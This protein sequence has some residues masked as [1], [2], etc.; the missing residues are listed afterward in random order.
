MTIHLPW[1]L[2]AT[3]DFACPFLLL[4]KHYLALR[5]TNRALSYFER[6]YR[7]DTLFLS[8]YREASQVFYQ[9]SQ[10]EQMIKV[11][12]RALNHGNRYW[13]IYYNLGIAFMIGNDIHH[14]I[15]N[16]NRALEIHPNNYDTNLQLG[17]AV[18]PHD[19]QK[20]REYFNNAINIDPLRQ[21][22]VDSL[23]KLNELQ[24]R[25]AKAPRRSNEA[26]RS[27]RGWNEIAMGWRK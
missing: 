12:Q 11:L 1:R 18:A 15:E 5:D 24:R 10:P 22:A 25:G 20:A 19:Y 2:G 16:F 23:M 14:A 4:G 9:M 17:G 8:A 3:P 27:L 7:L 21:E 6:S 13:E 26:S